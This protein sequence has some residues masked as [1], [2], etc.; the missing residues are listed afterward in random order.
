[1]QTQDKAIEAQVVNNDSSVDAN[2]KSLQDKYGK[3]HLESL[4]DREFYQ[5]YK[6]Y[7]ATGNAWVRD[8]VRWW[9]EYLN[10]T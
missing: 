9:L 3:E 5:L 1:M 7:V 2:L 8:G 4:S 6:S 10:K